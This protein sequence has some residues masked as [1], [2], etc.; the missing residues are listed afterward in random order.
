MDLFSLRFKVA[1]AGHSYVKW[2]H[3]FILHDNVD[4]IGKI[5]TCFGIYKEDV[6]VEFHPLPGATLFELK[7]KTH[8]ILKNNPD[9]MIIIIGGNELDR[10]IAEPCELA[11]EVY[12][13]GEYLV[14]K[15]VKYVSFMQVVER[16]TNKDFGVR[17]ELYNSRMRAMTRES[18]WIRLWDL[19][20]I[21]L[22]DLRPDGVH[23]NNRGNYFLYNGIKSCIRHAISHI[24]DGTPCIHDC[25]RI[26]LRGGKRCRSVKSR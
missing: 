9:I 4:L 17:S 7:C 24:A 6:E 18:P 23:L 16:N 21:G 14:S 19:R 25:E 13:Y 15:G 11:R 1:I 20:R 2:L 10:A 22:K 26:K 3:Q 5:D 8:A 12:A